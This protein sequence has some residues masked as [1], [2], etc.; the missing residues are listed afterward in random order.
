[1]TSTTGQELQNATYIQ[2]LAMM[3]YREAWIQ[4]LTTKPNSL[5]RHALEVTMDGL[6]PSIA[7]NAEDPI[8][9]A[10][11]RTLPEF[12]ASNVGSGS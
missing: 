5:A 1:M 8:W 11:I 3:K 9:L 6:Q 2:R 12:P 7:D 4:R 10:F